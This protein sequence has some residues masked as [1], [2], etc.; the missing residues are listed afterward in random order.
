M[1]GDDIVG[2]V[3]GAIDAGLRGVLVRTGKFRPSDENHPVVKPSGI[4][5]NLAQA[6]ELILQNHK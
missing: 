4:V 1:I 3:Q 5:D 6:V 2:D